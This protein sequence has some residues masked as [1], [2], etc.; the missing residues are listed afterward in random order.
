MQMLNSPFSTQKKTNYFQSWMMFMMMLVITLFTSFGSFSQT[1][2]FNSSGSY[3]VPPGVT[4]ITVYVWG[5]GGGGGGGSSDC[6]AQGE[7]SGGGGGGFAASTIAVNPGETYTVTVGAAGAA[8]AFLGNGGAGGT[9]T[10][11]GIGGTVTATGGGAGLGGSACGTVAGGT[12]GTGTV[13]TIFFSGGDGSAGITTGTTSQG[14]SG[15]GGGGAGSASNG[16]T[17]NTGCP[18]TT[19]TGGTGVFAGGN[20][21]VTA[22]C[23][24]GTSAAGQAG[25]IRG[26]GGSGGQ[27]WTGTTGVGGA[28]GAGQII[29]I[30]GACTTPAVQ[31]TA[32]TLTPVSSTQINGSFTAAAGADGYLVVRYPVGNST[33]APVNGTSYAAGGSL[34]TGTIVGSITGTT[35]SATGLTLSTNYDFYVYAMN[36]ICVGGPLYQPASPLTSTAATPAA[37]TT[38]AL[39]GLWSSPA[40]WALGVVPPSTDNVVIASGAIVTIDQLVTAPNLTINGTLQ[41]N[42]TA[43]ALTLTGNLTIGA[44][45]KLLAYT[46]G[47]AN[48]PVNIAGNYTNNGFA[49]HAATLASGFAVNF[50]G[51]SG[52]TLSGT[53]TFEGDGTNGI[54]RSLAFQNTGSNVISTSQTLIVPSATGNTNGL[55]HTAGSLNTGGKLK[56]DNTA[57]VYGRPLNTQVASVAVTTMGA[58]Y[59]TNAPVVFGIA[60]TKYPLNTGLVLNTRYFA[61]NNV[62]LCTTAGTSGAANPTTTGNT[63]FA[64]GPNTLQLLY[65]GNVGQ[66][67]VPYQTTAANTVGTQY[68]FQGTLYTALNAV[69]PTVAGAAAL[70]TSVGTVYTA[71]T[72][73]M[74]C[75]GTSASVSVNFDGPTQSVRSLALTSAG[76]GY[77]SAPALVFSNSGTTPT[78]AASATVVYFQQIVGVV[79]SVFQKSGSASI[80]GGLTINSDQGTSV[81]TL[82]GQ[83]SSGV[84]AI[85]TTNGGVNYTVAPTVGFAGPTAVNLV[86]NSGTV[87]SYT[88]APTITVDA[89]NLVTGTNLTS[90]NFT[91]TMNQGQIVSIY[92]NSSTTATYS[93]PPTITLSS[94]LGGATIGW[95]SGCWPSATAVIGSNRQLT[96]FTINSPGFGYV[97]APTVGIGTTSGG[98]LGGTFTT[99]ATAPTARIALYNLILSN[100]TPSPT[101]GVAADDAAI[102]ANRKLNVLSVGSGGFGGGLTLTGGNLTLFGTTPLVLSASAAGNIFDLGGANINCTWSS[103]AGA[104]STFGATSA[105]IKNGS[106]TLT[107]RGGVVTSTF[108][109]PFSGQFNWTPG[110]TPTAVTTGSTVTRVTVT[111][112]GAPSGTGA[113]GT[114]A[115][116]VNNNGGIQGLNPTVTMNYNTVDAISTS[117]NATDLFIS[118]ATALGGAWTPRSASSGSGTIGTSGTRTTA[119]AVP[120]PWVPTGNDYFAW[121]TVSLN[122]SNVTVAPTTCA[123][124][125]HLVSADVTSSIGT[126]SGVTIT[127]NNGAA[128]GPIAMTNTGGNTW[129][130]TIPAASPSNAVVTW[131]LT[132]T[133]SAGISKTFTGTS[134]QDDALNGSV[135]TATATPSTVCSGLPSV[136]TAKTTVSSTGTVTI[137]TQTT[138]E[139]T[140]QP[141]RTGLGAS[142]RHQYLFLASEM[143]AAGFGAG[144]NLNSI[145]FT[146]TTLG[147][148]SLNNYSI[149][150]SNVPETVLTTTFL[151][152]ASPTTVYSA[153]LPPQP[154]SGVNTYT[155]TSPFTWNGTSSVL[156]DICYDNTTIG[157][158][159]TAAATTPATIRSIGT[160]GITGACT[161]TSASTAANRPLTTFNGVLINDLT[162]TI[163]WVWNPGAIAG[164]NVTVTPT[165]TTTYTAS[166]TSTSGCNVTTPPVTVTVLPLPAAP[167]P[168][169]STQC[170]TGTPAAFVTS[171]GGGGGYN[172]YLTPTGGT[173]LVGQSGASLT[174][175]PISS[176]THFYVAEIGANGCESPRTDVFADVNSPDAILASV[177]NNNPCANSSIQLS[178]VNSASVPNNT[179]SY[180]WTSTTGSGLSAVPTPGASINVT[181]TVAGTYTYTATGTDGSCVT[182]ST[183]VVIVKAQPSAI[184]FT[185]T[186]P[187]PICAGA[188]TTITAISPGVGATGNASSGTISVAI[189]DVNAAGI[190]NAL[191]VSGIPAGAVIDSVITTFSITHGFVEDLV[192]SLQAPNGQ[193]INLV[194]GVQASGANFANTRVSSDNTKPA[195]AAAGAPYTG[196]YKAA[197]TLSGFQ[198]APTTLPTTATFSSL[199]STPNGT[200]TLRVHDDESIGSGTLTSWSIKIAY[201][202]PNPI[203]WAPA[204][205]LNTPSGI[206]VIASP[207]TTTTYT[208][209]ATNAA[210]CT[211]TNTIT[212]TVNPLP[213]APAASNGTDQCGTGLSDMSVSSNNI[214]DPQVPPFFKWYD[215]P[216]GGVLKQSGTSTTYTT[217]ITA[218]TTFYVAEVSANGC[219]GPRSP[220]TTIVSTADPLS[221]T[222]STGAQACIGETFDLTSSYTPDFNNYATFTLS[223]TPL[224]G[225]GL[226]GSV[227][228]VA[229]PTGS[230]AYPVT[231]TAT[232]TYTY[233][234]TA[235]DP[236]KN[237]TGA[238]S[239]VVTVNPVPT[240]VTAGTSAS[241]VCTGGTVNLNST[242][243]SNQV[244]PPTTLLTEGF[245]TFP[246]TGWTMLTVN[247]GSSWI[248]SSTL[249]TPTPHTGAS[250][251]AY[252]YNSSL[253]A[254]TWAITPGQALNG[255]LT[256]TLKFWYN[257]ASIGGAYPE[258]LK[259]TSGTSNTVAAQTNVLWDNNGGSDLINET[260]A[261]AVVTFTPAV[262]G[263]YYF[264]FNC[265]SDADMDALFVDD[266]EIVGPGF[267]PASFA[268][269][270][271][272]AGFT[273]NVQNPTGVVVNATTTYS[274][275]ASNSFGCSASATV[276]VTA[277]PLPA[278]P[279]TNSP[280]TRCGPGVVN[281]TATGGSG[282]LHWYNVASGGTSLQT[283]GSYSPTVSASTSFWVAET[284]E[285]GCEGPRSQV[286]VTLTPPP[287]LV[288]TPATATA[289]CLGGS[290]G[291][292]KTGSDASYSNF[293]WSATP[294]TAGLSATSGASITATPT[295]AGTYTITLTADDGVSG[296]TG[297]ANVAT[298]VLTVNP[299]PAVTTVT[300]TPATIC[301]G[302]TSEL[303]A[304][305]INAAAGTAPT[306]TT[307]LL[308]G[309]TQGGSPFRAGG[310]SETKTQILY[311]AAELTAAGFAPGNFTAIGFNF[312]SASGG[313]L[314]NFTIKMGHTTATTL[315]GAGTFET[316]PATTVFAPSTV[317]P[318]TV[319]GIFTLT[320]TTPFNW[321]G[322]SNLL[323]QFCHDIPT[324]AAGSGFVDATTTT[325]NMTNQLLTTAAC[326]VNT[327]GLVQTARPVAILSGQVGVD[328][329]NTLNWTWQPGNL[330]GA[331]QSVQPSVTTVYTVTATNPVTNCS[332]TGTVTVNVTPVGANATATPSTP[333]CAGTSVTLNAGA[334]GGAPFTYAWAS[335]PAGTYTPDA[336]ITVTP[337][338]TTVYTVTVTDACGNPTTSTVT[339]T[340]NPLPTAS[341]QEAGPITI[342][343]PATQVLHA[344][345]D[346]GAPTYQWTLNGV[347]IGAATGPTYTVT[348][349]GSGVYRVVIT[350]SAT[351]CVNT[352]SPVTVTINP[353]PSAVTVTPPTATLCNGGSQLL[354]ASGGSTGGSGSATLGTGA[355]VTTLST[356]GTPYRVGNT[357]G[358]QFKNQYLF[359]ASELQAQGIIAGNIT[360]VALTI[361]GSG[362]GT[363]SNF[364]IKMGATAQTALTSTYVTGLTTVLSLATYPATGTVTT[365]VQSHTFTTAFNWDGTSNVV[366]EM[367]AQLATGGSAGTLAGDAL[368]FNG[369]ILNNPTTTACASATTGGGVS[370]VRPKVTFGYTTLQSPTWS[371]TPATGLSATNVA[372]VTASPSTTTVYTATA[373]NSFGCTNTGTATVTVNPR[374]TAVISGSGAYCQ[375]TS[376]TTNLTVNFTGTA[377][378]N[379]TYTVDGGSPVSGTTSSNPL[380]IT[381]TPSNAAGHVFT[382]A[383][384][385]L[386]D[387]NCTSIAADLTGTGTVTVN[388]LAA[389]PTASVVQPTCALGT[390]TI[391]VTSPLGGGNTYSL[392]GINFQ[393]SPSFP[394]QAPGTYTVYVNNSF[395]CFSPATVNVTVN[396]Q[397]FTPGAPVVT[398]IVNVCPFIGVAG[399]AGQLTYTATATGNG[400][401]T[402]NWVVPPTLVTIV[403]GQGTP[404]LVLSFANGFATQP[405]KQIR[406]TV[407]NECGT[408]TMTIYY[409]L[410]QIPNT[411]APIVGP[412]DACPLLGGPAVAY[413]I[414]KAPG[415][416]EYFWSVPAGASFTR[417]NGVGVN[418][419]TILVSFTAGY[420]T[421]PITVQSSNDCGVSGIRSLTVT[422]IAPSQPNIIS[423][424]TNACPYITPNAP[425]TYTV[426]AVPGVT[427][428]WSGTNGAVM[429]SPQGSNTMSVS[430]PIGY[431]GGTI[432][433]TAST[434]CGT[435]APRNL[436]ITT[437]N[438]ATPG[439]IDVVQTHFCGDANGREFTYAISAMPA[440]ATSVVW[441]VPTAAGAILLS[442]QN[443]TQIT[444]RYPNTAVTG[445]VTVQ[446]VNPCA[447]SV[448][449]SVNVKLAACPV[450]FAGNNAGTN[451]TAE[452]KGAITPAK[453]STPASAL[454]EAMEVKIFP[455]PTVSDFKLEVL[456]SGTEEITVRVLDN[457]GR[458]YKNFKVM[459]YQTIALGAELKAGSY[460]VEVRQGKTV[461]TTKVIRF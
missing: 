229:N 433:V 118:Q 370:T 421:G 60:V 124:T 354:T 110:T 193:I 340:V 448:I 6:S 29:V 343:A 425:A 106:M 154:V 403:S 24:V 409:L 25:G 335:T 297:C 81:A 253:P 300:A 10:F 292:S 179:Y 21:G 36:G 46:T 112:T 35:F 387:A 198:L 215:A 316:A 271:S 161:A 434:G 111:E 402:F 303:S 412:T 334:T 331:T 389:N 348:T 423:G 53:G 400:T 134:Y 244:A 449:R 418:D 167:A 328:V 132:A 392:D 415:A 290:V 99:V 82:N 87:G 137:G 379:Y 149:K 66:L 125:A 289:F 185:P 13:G 7:G 355:D 217:P 39:G 65:I 9:S 48:A 339:V 440:N 121:T 19:G 98:V 319:T 141:F 245:E 293:T 238:N 235:F 329:T 268:W 67:G 294:A 136:L 414:T 450:T 242:A 281:L 43:N 312:T 47:G 356:D 264:G 159:S 56:I 40:T 350:N 349:V 190:S 70:G 251:L 307:G 270:S 187:S 252:L 441:T 97:A 301:D 427:Y 302:G 203:T 4:S 105:Y 416:K 286:T 194:N 317:N 96:N 232:G 172:W 266:F 84:G 385:A 384:S 452:S 226:P 277:L 299:N 20:G 338:V 18:G 234:I 133:N 27:G 257:T 445:T 145:A 195:M 156:V 288:I 388:P 216:S 401:Q 365:G 182:T 443:T 94:A 138:T 23:G 51:A 50:N 68:A 71:G 126:I 381:V 308:V 438:P 210:A 359:R 298:I 78:T 305:S 262:S 369:T 313:G 174:A 155:F 432:S 258:K 120:G 103:F 170:G 254:N 178:V 152:P 391:N 202:I 189:P 397:P 75:V 274:V 347:N 285:N 183:V 148:G 107:G 322:V 204:G 378:W 436:T 284:G 214:T 104:T 59:S 108:S 175:Y 188:N 372:A 38:T 461:K 171:G 116:L 139:S 304:T 34:G 396:P 428:T 345:T 16:T 150:M 61:G 261:Q 218:T 404:N 109:F 371:W 420:A 380:T 5:A 411:P 45:G 377:P 315:N 374:P 326:T 212:V 2:T 12:G 256:Y 146:I 11:T 62:Y 431:T 129:Q 239:V 180:G 237:C 351:G 240:S 163:N 102:P 100:Y 383:I 158:S 222:S 143:T 314:P 454:A 405:N 91:I 320:F 224:T 220:V 259:F 55:G 201:A 309:G 192:L 79:N 85:S 267:A 77:S 86:T 283:G 1:Q 49:N 260:Y 74:L 162:S 311:T 243:V 306:A 333:V 176:P 88:T 128:A 406:L 211:L 3:V 227:P 151:A 330:A 422:R 280:V 444:V 166:G 375:G 287:S 164:N 424:P 250:A 80:S 228:V 273:S 265:Y 429:S 122:Y 140:N 249:T 169:N 117:L 209:T 342:C 395:G 191:T 186:I 113:L 358:N 368:A 73:Q 373:T 54:I 130:Y 219:E 291:L 459:P 83:A 230:D 453:V 364:T 451:G 295:V 196:T 282:I 457:L 382:Y 246:P 276:N 64:E 92:L 26:G 123:A 44:S 263:T 197:A 408:S 69:T 17:P 168:N 95:P 248:A 114:R 393:P 153:T 376:T 57:Q 208:A 269:T 417:P 8:G 344:V 458:L 31:P 225:S 352:S 360:S 33:T 22:S 332:S 63:P 157:S 419:T 272:P 76:S 32:L 439:N 37:S 353:Q 223:V 346:V 363:L 435:S 101:V 181:P 115:F 430:Y 399:A 15:K 327:G 206:T 221:V 160:Q 231:P 236:D 366:L 357:V 147:S 460:L 318:P 275:T 42:A 296:P 398:G 361:A 28:G 205:S 455:N 362:G 255:G 394:G 278:A 407:T 72:A 90:S 127:Y 52:S 30:F 213:P 325:G 324:G 321:D 426:P 41:W 199:Y 241:S 336:S 386:S 437:L 367:C 93:A 390:G 173:P 233:T 337:L 247:S 446:A 442:G 200:W 144:S 142:S 413:T 89:T 341:I 119:T 14:V 456:T 58:G 410:A 310:A 279:S 131:S 135:T 447:N 177:D 165:I 207:S 184:V 323:I